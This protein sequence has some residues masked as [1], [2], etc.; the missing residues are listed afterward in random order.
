[1]SEPRQ[2]KAT[3]VR[4]LGCLVIVLSWTVGVDRAAGQ[5]APELAEGGDRGEG[6]VA[7]ETQPPP[8]EET[9]GL[10]SLVTPGG[11]TAQQVADRVEATAPSLARARAAVIIAEA[12][13]N[14][15]FQQLIP[16]LDLLASY[17]R[18]SNVEQGGLGSSLDQAAID[19]TRALINTVND[20]PARQLFGA[21]FDSQL[22][23]SN[24]QFPIL[25]NQYL[26][27]ATLSYP[28]SDLFLQVLPASRANDRLVEAEQARLDDEV[29]QLRLQA[30]EAFLQLIRA[31]GARAVAEASL[32]Q[33]EAQQRQVAL[34]VEAGA[35]ARVDLLRLDAQVASARVGVAQASNGVRVA[36]FALRTLMHDPEVQ[37]TIGEDVTQDLS[38]VASDA[39]AL[40]REAEGR[41]AVRA[42]RK[43]IVAQEELAEAAAG[44]RWPHLSIRGNVDIANP[45]PRVFP[46]TDAFRSTWDIGA[47][48]SWSPNDYLTADEDLQRARAQLAQAEADEQALMDAIMLEVENGLTADETAREAL[49]AALAG[50]EAAEEAY[51]VRR[52]QLDVGAATVTDIVNA[53]T[54][55]A[56]ARLQFLNAAVDQRLARARLERAVGRAPEAEER[57]QRAAP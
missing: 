15:T 25:L 48:L 42:I 8:A 52:Q 4:F 1:M 27:R 54:D 39:E 5:A 9:F 29:L 46:Q 20:P 16:R 12:G 44:A 38:P 35:M 13:A 26:F 34:M 32:A 30:K 40:A 3:P 11:L 33:A 41:P 53:Q 21:F 22:A 55:L 36:E 2:K 6:P 47:V 18:F 45:N 57:P 51:R 14:Q 37:L 19:A 7:A 28:V 10:A 50:E 31:R 23:F 17:T 56:N 49:S 43:A 24:F